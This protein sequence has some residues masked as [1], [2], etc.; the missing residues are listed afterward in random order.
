M[1]PCHN[2][3]QRTLV[4]V[5]GL[6]ELLLLNRVFLLQSYWWGGSWARCRNLSHQHSTLEKLFASWAIGDVKAQVFFLYIDVL[7]QKILVIHLFILQAF[8]CASFRSCFIWITGKSGLYIK[9]IIP[10]LPICTLVTAVLLLKEFSEIGNSNFMKPIVLRGSL[11]MKWSNWTLFVCFFPLF[12][13]LP[14][15]RQLYQQLFNLFYFWSIHCFSQS[16]Q[17]VNVIFA[18]IRHSETQISFAK[19]EDKVFIHLNYACNPA[20]PYPATSLL[21]SA[22]VY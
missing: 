17:T 18:L 8:A 16:P 13:F 20:V 10:I 22:L 12:C 14:C 9:A 2:A 5:S 7:F 19:V 6:T 15:C 11:S 21:S 4:V 3:S 1:L